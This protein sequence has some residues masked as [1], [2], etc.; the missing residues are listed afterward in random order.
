[1]ATVYTPIYTTNI[2]STPL[3]ILYMYM[4]CVHVHT[5]VK[6]HMIVPSEMYPETSDLAAAT[7]DFLICL[8]MLLFSM[9]HH[10]VFS[11]QQFTNS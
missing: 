5:Q 2:R 1:M 3:S 9:V 11:Y 6:E 8:E 4:I 7:Q 10:W